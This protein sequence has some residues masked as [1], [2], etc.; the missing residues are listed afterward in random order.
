[1]QRETLSIQLITPDTQMGIA[2][3][4]SPDRIALVNSGDNSANLHS[5]STY[6]CLSDLSVPTLESNTKLLGHSSASSRAR[7]IYR[8][9]RSLTELLRSRI[10]EPNVQI[11]LWDGTIVGNEAGSIGRIIIRRPRILWRLLMN[12]EV[13]FGEAFTCQDLEIDG[14]L[15]AVLTELNIGL[16]KVARKQGL[17]RLF[18]PW[19]L[20]GR[21]PRQ[22]LVESRAS[23]HHH[24]DM[25]NDFYKLWLDQQL[26]YTCAYYHGATDS[27]E[28]AQIAKMGHICRKLR[29]LPGETVVEAGCGWGALALHMAREYGVT[30]KAYNLSR[31]QLAYARERADAE[32]LRNQ[33]EFI[34]DD[35][36]NIQGRFDVF[37][38]VGMLEHVGPKNYP[39]MGDLMRKVLTDNG[40][41]LIHSIGRNFAAPLDS[42][43][44][45]NIFPGACPPS[46]KEMMDL[47]ESSSFSVM[48]VENL[49][50]H[51]ARTCA[52][53]LE[54]FERQADRVAEMFDPEFVR[55][56][57]L[58][59]AGS[60]A[61]FVSG[62]LQLFQIV[63]ARATNNQLP[64]TRAD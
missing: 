27:L 64:W 1:M 4:P 18:Q 6:G 28:S 22:T 2:Q 43:I 59:L 16:A 12:S 34:E 23:V 56:W 26:V 58:Y 41:G 62:W 30:V 10:G 3:H 50:L 19:G 40:R 15:V 35:Y 48:D 5:V 25:G 57:R 17:S 45:R 51:Y 7:P 33:V 49:R 61:A 37:V 53:W 29:L 60:S 13:A 54:R 52:Q 36:R 9:T 39:A 55:M 44:E 47:F 11:E 38:S 63:F 14:D 24:Y 32:G 46:L 8:F 21:R 20:T 31:E 42:W